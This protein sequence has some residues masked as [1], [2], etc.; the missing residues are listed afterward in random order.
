MKEQDKII[1]HI[2]LLKFKD[3]RIIEKI[4]YHP[5]LF[6]RQKMTDPDDYKPIRIRYFGAF[7]PKYMHSKEM[8][9]KLSYIIKSIKEDHSL[10][11]IF[12]DPKFDNDLQARIY[13]NKLFD[14]GAKDAILEIYDKIKDVQSTKAIRET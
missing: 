4:V 10:K 8:Y 7:V 3:K 11:D 13:I 6:A 1:K 2:S 9:N 5:L 12:I 14:Q